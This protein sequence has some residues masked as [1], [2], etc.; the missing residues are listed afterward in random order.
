M[1][2]VFQMSEPMQAVSTWAFLSSGGIETEKPPLVL[3]TAEPNIGKTIIETFSSHQAFSA[4][5]FLNEIQCL[6]ADQKEN[7]Q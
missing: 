1:C 6:I 4:L 7:N 3:R 5:Q 2:F